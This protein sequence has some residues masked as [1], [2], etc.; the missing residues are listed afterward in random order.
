MIVRLFTV[1][2]NDSKVVYSI[3]NDSK[4]VYSIHNDSK[5]VYG[6]GLVFNFRT[7]ACKKRIRCQTTLF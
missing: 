2:G 6:I 5:V 4:V 7:S 3:H 1:F